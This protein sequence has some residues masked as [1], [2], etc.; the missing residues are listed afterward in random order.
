M[1]P[2]DDPDLQIE[3][4]V[5]VEIEDEDFAPVASPKTSQSGDAS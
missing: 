4:E 3:I 5:P 2:L 1:E